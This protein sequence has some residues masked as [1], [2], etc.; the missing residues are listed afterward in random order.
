[1]DGLAHV[2][3]ILVAIGL[4]AV[5][6]WYTVRWIRDRWRGTGKY[7][8]KRRNQ[9]EADSPDF[10]PAVEYT[11]SAEPAAPQADSAPVSSNF[12]FRL[13]YANALGRL[14]D[15]EWEHLHKECPAILDRLKKATKGM[16]K[17]DHQYVEGLLIATLSAI[18][19]AYGKGVHWLEALVLSDLAMYAHY[20]N[21]QQDSDWRFRQSQE[22]ASKWIAKYP[23]LNEV[24]TDKRPYGW[25]YAASK[26]SKR[27]Y[28][29]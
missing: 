29:F 20:S 26:K 22:V 21:R 1:M 4:C 3:T 24:C 19:S 12:P 17:G 7:F 28:W 16:E 8:Q 27:K 10:E 9:S 14:C 13:S 18:R 11:P 2:L 15:A 25:M 6:L 5:L 23:W